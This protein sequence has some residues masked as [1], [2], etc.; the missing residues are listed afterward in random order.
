MSRIKRLLLSGTIAVLIVLT[1]FV[2]AQEDAKRDAVKLSARGAFYQ[3]LSRDKRTELDGILIFTEEEIGKDDISWRL[4]P[5]EA[6][7]YRGNYPAG[8]EK[9]RTIGDAKEALEYARSILEEQNRIGDHD[10]ELVSI[11]HLAKDNLWLFRYW[12]VG[13]EGGVSGCVIDGNSG[14]YL[15][16]WVEE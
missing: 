4:R 14:E 1:V 10:E 2:W 16:G 3:A 6:P 9:N 5:L 12:L 8:V 11:V 13:Y 15:K 7:L